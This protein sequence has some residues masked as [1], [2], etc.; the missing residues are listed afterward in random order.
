LVKF[1]KY[2]P[3]TEEKD[4]DVENLK[5][6]IKTTEPREPTEAGKL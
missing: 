1:A 2:K 5:A 6:I 3:S 4:K